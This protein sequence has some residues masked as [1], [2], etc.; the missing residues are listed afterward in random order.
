MSLNLTSEAAVVAGR[1]G[2]GSRPAPGFLRQ[3]PGLHEGE[4]SY[5]SLVTPEKAIADVVWAYE[6]PYEAVEAIA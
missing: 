3:T 4:A 1:V 6:E 5:F 2:A